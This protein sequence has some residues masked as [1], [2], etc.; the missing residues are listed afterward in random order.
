MKIALFFLLIPAVWAQQDVARILEQQVELQ[1]DRVATVEQKLK[2]TD[3]QIERRVERV[4]RNLTAVTDSPDSRTKVLQAKQDIFDALKRNIEFYARERGAR[5]MQPQSATCA[6][7][8][9]LLNDRIE[10]RVDQAL[11]LVAS[12][13]AER[14]VNRT[15]T[16]YNGDDWEERTNPAYTHQR[17]VMDQAG[18]F[19]ERAVKELKLSLDRIARNRVELERRANRELLQRNADLV[20]KRREQI[21]TALGTTNPNA[22]PLGSKA[23]DALLEQIREEKANNAKDNA[24]WIRLKN[25]RDLEHTRLQILQARLAKATQP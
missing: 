7:D 22:K 16:R 6:T 8:I 14:D 5:F 20:E 10:K 1:R 9:Q 2:A 17:R 25:E 19:R 11:A 4:L 23:A 12:L 24:E 15:T 18:Q 13:P 3:D 21:Q